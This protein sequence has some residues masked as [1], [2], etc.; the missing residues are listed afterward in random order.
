MDPLLRCSD[1]LSRRLFMT[2]TA[3]SLLGVGLLPTLAP[4]ALALQK[5]I[6]PRPTARKVIYLYMAGG[7]SHLDT[8]DPKPES[9]VQGPVASIRTRADGVFLSEH[10]PA[11]AQQ[12]D[13][14][15]LI[16]SVSSTQGAHEQGA[17]Y[18]HSS[19][20]MRGTIKHPGLGAWIEK[21]EGKTNR[22]LPAT[23]LIG[24]GNPGS[25]SGWMESH[26]APLLLSNP[27]EGLRNSRRPNS[28][29]EEEFTNRLALAEAFDRR[30]HSRY[31]TRSV[32]AYQ[33]MYQDAVRLMQSED[34]KAFDIDREPA[35]C[36]DLYGRNSF[37]DG[38]LLARRLIEHDVRFV[39]V[40]LGG[41]DTHSNNFTSVARQASTLDRGLSGLLVDLAR[42][43]L[44]EETL[45][46]V[47]TEF[48]RTPQINEDDGRDHFPKAFSC[49]L[50]GGGIQGGR[51][52]G[53]TDAMGSDIVENPVLIPDF[54][55]TIAYA[56]GL[57]VDKV[58]YSP[59]KRPFKVAHDGRPVT[60]LF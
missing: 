30:F 47:A 34:L 2:R 10:F 3:R 4:A 19:Y 17:Y 6:A 53:A 1:E 45:V 31:S 8:F 51:A 26:Y 36:R 44:L 39:E 49:L 35:E 46:V 57:P 7:M 27:H 12:M 42:R 50:A 54:N 33:G 21:L 11:L 40:S 38:C 59:T 48:G 25:G 24:G 23:V 56:L 60:A 15:A 41:W 16:R 43:G 37:G 18:M 58:V 32:Q 5:P 55:A 9:D 22:T 20:V 28:I 13:K 29:A 14:V 52:Y